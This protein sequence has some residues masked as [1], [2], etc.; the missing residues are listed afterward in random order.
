[1]WVEKNNPE[2]PFPSLERVR[3]PGAREPAA[4]PPCQRPAAR[5]QL[6]AHSRRCQRM[7]TVQGAAAPQ[8]SGPL[9][10]TWGPRFRGLPP[11][12]NPRP[13]RMDDGGPSSRGGPAA[14]RPGLKGVGVL[15]GGAHLRREQLCQQRSAGAGPESAELGRASGRPFKVPGIRPGPAP[16]PPPARSGIGGA[17]CGRDLGRGGLGSGPRCVPSWSRTE[18]GPQWA[19]GRRAGGLRTAVR[20]VPRLPGTWI[21]KYPEFMCAEGGLREKDMGCPRRTPV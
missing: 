3:L 18:R 13:P 19:A 15:R 12:P 6:S 14:P 10:Q 1:M 21:N 20:R 11:P 4:A 7:L 8:P 2:T 5:A 9:G 16:P 17:G